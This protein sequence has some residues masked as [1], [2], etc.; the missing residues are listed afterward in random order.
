MIDP[1][2]LP[3]LCCPETRQPLRPADPAVLA[4]VNQSITAGTAK[5]HAGRP[6]TGT[7][8]AAL[9]REDGKLLYP[10]RNQIPLLIAEEGIAVV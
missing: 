10:V 9:I 3:L 8:E 7:L 4:R 1:K 2:L 6:V 5:N